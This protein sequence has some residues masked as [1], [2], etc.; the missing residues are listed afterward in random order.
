MPENRQTDEQRIISVFS[1][2]DWS[3][4]FILDRKSRGLSVNI[5]PFY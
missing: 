2:L 1:I 3:E 4:A 5:I